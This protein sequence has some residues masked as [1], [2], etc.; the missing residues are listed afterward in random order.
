MHG[1]L[2]AVGIAIFLEGIVP[3]A[4]PRMFR[5]SIVSM[6]QISDLGLRIVGFVAIAVGVALVYLVRY[7]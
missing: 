4:S 5:R 3:F 2:L 6:L 7:I 1:L